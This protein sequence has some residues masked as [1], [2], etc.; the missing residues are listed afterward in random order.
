[1]QPDPR[2]QGQRVQF[3]RRLNGAGLVNGFQRFGVNQM[4]A[5]GQRGT[6]GDIDFKLRRKVF[7]VLCKSEHRVTVLFVEPATDYAIL[8][9]HINEERPFVLVDDLLAVK[10][11]EYPERLVAGSERTEFRHNISF[12]GR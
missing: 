2:R 8:R 1:L 3:L 5:G 12:G 6:L 4:P 7:A 9:M 11:D 10:L